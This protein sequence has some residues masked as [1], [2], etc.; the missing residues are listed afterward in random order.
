MH[1]S[2][3]ALTSLHN[4]KRNLS[5]ATHRAPASRPNSAIMY[6][7][8]SEDHV[9]GARNLKVRPVC[10]SRQAVAWRV[11]EKEEHYDVLHTKIAL[12]TDTRYNAVST[13]QAF[14]LGLNSSC[15]VYTVTA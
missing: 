15:T 7:M 10:A 3:N 4:H 14:V 6:T 12:H 13:W 5:P 2:D 1:V 9:Q 11:Q 8:L